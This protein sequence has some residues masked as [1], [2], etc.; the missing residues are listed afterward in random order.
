MKN[1]LIERIQQVMEDRQI[2]Q[3]DLARITKIRASS[4][5]DYLSGKYKPKQDKIALIA[6]ALSVSPGW[7]MGYDLDTS[8]S[9]QPSKFYFTHE[10]QSLIKKYRRLTPE[11][12]ETVDT[13]LDL[14]YRIAVPEVK[15]EDAI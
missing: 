12:K 10:E 15:N 11:G 4:I 13:I 5:S 3:A 1:I 9:V 7:L 6:E 2:S 8:A 14:Q